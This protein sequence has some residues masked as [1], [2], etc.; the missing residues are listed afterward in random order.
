M[1]V[2]NFLAFFHLAVATK[3]LSERSFLSNFNTFSVRSR[4]SEYSKIYTVHFLSV[5]KEH[6]IWFFEYSKTGPVRRENIIMFCVL[7]FKKGEATFWTIWLWSIMRSVSER[8]AHSP[9]VKLGFRSKINLLVILVQ[10]NK[11]WRSFKTITRMVSGV[12]LYDSC[13]VHCEPFYDI[14]CWK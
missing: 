6:I 12:F 5:K 14:N 3:R 7:V 8:S 11:L 10:K 9:I 2:A 1:K 13:E 4:F